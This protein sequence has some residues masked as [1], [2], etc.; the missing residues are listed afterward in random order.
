MQQRLDSETNIC[1]NQLLN[2]ILIKT[3]VYI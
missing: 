1:F 2:G 3:I